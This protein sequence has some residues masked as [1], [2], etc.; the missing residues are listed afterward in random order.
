MNFNIF[1]ILINSDFFFIFNRYIS[2]NSN[3]LIIEKKILTIKNLSYNLKFNIIK[4]ANFNNFLII[5]LK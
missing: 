4:I 2:N 5:Y 3:I 1:F